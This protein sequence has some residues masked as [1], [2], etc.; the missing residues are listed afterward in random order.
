MAY[1]NGD[2]KSMIHHR[3]I[4]K[5]VDEYRLQSLLDPNLNVVVS[6]ERIDLTDSSRLEALLE[7][8]E[9]KLQRIGISDRAV[10]AV[11]NIILEL[12]GNVLL[13]GTG[14]RD[15][16][17]LLVVSLYDGAVRLWMFGHGRPS[18]IDRLYRVIN[19]IYEIAKPPGH[20]EA[21]LRKRNEELYRMSSSPA[22]AELGGGAGML[23]I[24]ALSREPI[25]MLKSKVHDN[26]FALSSV[27]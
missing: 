25:W 6:A 2:A 14:S 21:L 27:V 8:V 13:H 20:R 17:E 12:A 11:K 19:S 3:A 9:A 23:T 4:W 1:R 26:S 7:S 15:R 16:E 22:N 18:Q 10:I 5:A 24:A